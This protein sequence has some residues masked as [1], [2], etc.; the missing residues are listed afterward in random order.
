MNALSLLFVLSSSLH[1]IAQIHFPAEK[2]LKNVRQLTFDGYNIRARFSQNGR[3]IVYV[4]FGDVYE[5]DCFQVYRID[6]CKPHEPPFRLSMGF[7]EF[8]TASFFPDNERV[9]LTTNF[10]S[11]L[12]LG[13]KSVSEICELKSMEHIFKTFCEGEVCEYDLFEFN[14]YG[15]I[16][17]RL[18]AKN[19]YVEAAISSDGQWVA[20]SRRKNRTV[21][22]LYLMKYD[23]SEMWKVC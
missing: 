15:N 23:G 2:H 1:L 4:A 16:R 6:L 3:Y 20:Y 7:G 9:L 22:D 19:R 21:D 10:H 12:P 17:R 8:S 14:K 13:N 18:T 5:S 11:H